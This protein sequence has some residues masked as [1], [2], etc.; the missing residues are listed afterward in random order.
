M[1]WSSE[2]PKYG[3]LGTYPPETGEEWI[4]PAYSALVMAA[5]RKGAGKIDES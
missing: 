1:L 5:R 3:G 2:D 4:L